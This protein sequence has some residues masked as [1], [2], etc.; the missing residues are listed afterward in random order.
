MGKKENIKVDPLARGMAVDPFAEERCCDCGRK[1]PPPHALNKIN[2]AHL[3]LVCSLDLCESKAPS[4]KEACA[5]V[6]VPVATLPILLLSL[7]PTLPNSFSY[8]SL[9]NKKNNNNH[10]NYIYWIAQQTTSIVLVVLV[11]CLVVM[12]LAG[13]ASTAVTRE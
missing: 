5:P 10:Y 7:Y 6:A 3:H 2:I 13:N 8:S 12:I 4:R 11:L 9:N 1:P